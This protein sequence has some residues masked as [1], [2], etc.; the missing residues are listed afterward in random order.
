MSGIRIGKVTHFF[1]HISVAM[2]ALLEKPIKVGEMVHFLGHA[3]DF[4]QEVRSL[5][6]EHQNMDETELCQMAR[7]LTLL[8]IKPQN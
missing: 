6:I 4:K 8:A 3:T 1:D 5:Q 7:K 2:L